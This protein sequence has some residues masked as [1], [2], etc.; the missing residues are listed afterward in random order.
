MLMNEHGE[1]CIW[2][3]AWTPSGA[4][5]ERCLSIEERVS[6]VCLACSSDPLDNAMHPSPS[7][8]PVIRKIVVRS[9]SGCPHLTS[10][11]RP[12]SDTWVLQDVNSYPA[13][14]FAFKSG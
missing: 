7:I 6:F 3:T 14:S 5:R 4:M 10:Q 13:R 9:R 2:D 12:S 1:A 8:F 11:T